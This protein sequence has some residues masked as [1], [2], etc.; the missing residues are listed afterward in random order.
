MSS[1]RSSSYHII[2]GE[3]LLDDRIPFRICE[4]PGEE[5]KSETF[6]VLDVHAHLLEDTRIILAIGWYVKECLDCKFRCFIIEVEGLT[7]KLKDDLELFPANS[8]SE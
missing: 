6:N 2:R 7:Q 4:N 1:K 8:I 5:G 3:D